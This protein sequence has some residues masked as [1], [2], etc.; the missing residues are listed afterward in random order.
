MK[1]DSLIMR[2]KPQTSGNTA[3]RGGQTSDRLMRF[4][5]TLGDHLAMGSYDIHIP[6]SLA[7]IVVDKPGAGVES[8]GG[9]PVR[10]EDEEAQCIGFGCWTCSQVANPNPRQTKVQ[11]S[12]RAVLLINMNGCI[13]EKAS[14]HTSSI[15]SLRQKPKQSEAQARTQKQVAIFSLLPCLLCATR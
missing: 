9:R 10:R 5:E 12:E 7:W 13:P 3:I 11:P 2:T 14:Q 6:C 15:S 1:L 4:A 8:E